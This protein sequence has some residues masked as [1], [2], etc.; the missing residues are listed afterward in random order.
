[1]YEPAI[2][3]IDSHM[4]HRAGAQPEE[5][6]VTRDQTG[7]VHRI[8]M[9]KLCARRPGNLNTGLVVC[10]IDQA[11][12]IKAARTGAAVMIGRAQHAGCDIEDFATAGF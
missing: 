10:V 8:R 2:T 5:Q 11:A 12:A 6:Q 9:A 3:R 1:M 4:G 7:T